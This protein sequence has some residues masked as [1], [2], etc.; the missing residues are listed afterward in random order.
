MTKD[1]AVKYHRAMWNWI[2]DEVERCKQTSHISI[3]KRIWCKEHEMNP[4][5]SCF[6]CEYDAQ[7]HGHPCSHCLFNRKETVPW[8]SCCEGYYGKILYAETWRERAKL[9]RKI[10]NLPVR[11]EV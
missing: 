7:F 4:I 1:E 8:A 5:A 6:A 9:A 10:A 2:A 3:L 11:E